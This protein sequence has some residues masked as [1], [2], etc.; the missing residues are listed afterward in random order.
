[1]NIELTVSGM[2]CGHCKTA[3]EGA[4]KR[5]NGVSN[6]EVDLAHGAAR[7]QGERVDLEALLAAVQD[8]GYTAAVARS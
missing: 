4:L 2:T 5:V 6:V 3:V 8:E 1:M 7:V